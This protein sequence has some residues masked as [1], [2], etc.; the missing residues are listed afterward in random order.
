MQS[1]PMLIAG[2]PVNSTEQDDVLNLATGRPFATCAGATAAHVQEAVAAAG[3]ASR[4]WRK[5]E[6][7]HRQK[8]HE[9]AAVTRPKDQDAAPDRWA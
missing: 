9:C 2:R 8:L 5:A 1:Y 7:L 6:A 4:T 3:R